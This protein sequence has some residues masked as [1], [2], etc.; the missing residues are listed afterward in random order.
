MVD[1]WDVDFA[2]PSAI[3]G[4]E[5]SAP[6]A[7]VV[8]ATFRRCTVLLPLSENPPMNTEFDEELRMQALDD[9]AAL[10]AHHGV[11]PVTPP[12]KPGESEYQA[13]TE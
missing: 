7:S 12:R 9:C 10:S 11:I 5:T 4:T 13:Y 2:A 1:G 3:A 8:A 6:T